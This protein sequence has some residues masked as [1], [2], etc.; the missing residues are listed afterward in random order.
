MLKS[1]QSAIS[2]TSVPVVVVVVVLSFTATDLLQ[3]LEKQAEGDGGL[4][5]LRL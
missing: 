2:S 4:A 5:R 3:L 1:Q